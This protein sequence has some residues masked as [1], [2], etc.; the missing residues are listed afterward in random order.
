MF[1]LYVQCLGKVG[2]VKHMHPSGD[3]TIVVDG[4]IWRF[5][6]LCLVIEVK[7]AGGEG[8]GGGGLGERGI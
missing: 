5:N 1:S 7:G 8:E 4:N 2:T 3:V 6:P